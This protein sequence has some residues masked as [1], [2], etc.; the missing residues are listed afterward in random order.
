MAIGEWL[1]ELGSPAPAPGGGAAAAMN[2]AVG[3]ALV[4]MVCN[5][6]MGKPRFADHERQVTAVRDAA[7]KLRADALGLIGD[8][9]AAF[10]ELMATHRLPRDTDEQ[11]K[12]HDGRIQSA[13]LL[14]ASV[15]MRIAAVGAEVA[16]L[17]AQLPD[18]SN[19]SVLSDVGVAAA[20]AAAAIEA[21]ALNVE[22]NL[23]TLKAQEARAEL[24]REL[25]GHLATAQTARELVTRV[26]Q[27]IA[28]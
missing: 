4:E 9:A 23:V 24:A 18:R 27:D 28:G 21:A 3:A 10:T 7:R 19:P 25:A 14:A 13:T 11:Q 2:A 6:T 16:R 22:I 15:P 1:A 26:R 20:S 5:L 8:D 12:R 17:A